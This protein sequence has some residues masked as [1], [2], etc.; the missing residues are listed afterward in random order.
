MY[1]LPFRF[2]L[3]AFLRGIND[4]NWD[5]I[6]RGIIFGFRVINEGCES[7]YKGCNYGSSTGDLTH[8]AMSENLQHESKVGMITV[9][10][11]SELCTHPIGTIPKSDS[12]GFRTIIDCS[13][14]K[15]TCVNVFTDECATKFAYKSIDDVTVEM[16]L[17]EFMS[18]VDI[19]YAYRA[20]SIQPS[21]TCRQGLS[22]QFTMGVTTYLKNNRLCMGLSSTPFVFSKIS[23]FIVWCMVR[24]GHVRITNYLDDF[25]SLNRTLSKGIKAQADVVA[26]LRFLGVSIS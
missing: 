5:Y 21:S 23:D 15:N 3:E 7:T 19:S 6:M 24:R 18:V 20:V 11:G 14:L 2:F 26:V 16:I 25:C 22:R 8:A 9:R 10:P 12:V 17:G 1:L 4:P 13:F